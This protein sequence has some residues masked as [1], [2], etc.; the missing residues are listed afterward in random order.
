MYD[1]CYSRFSI[2]AINSNQE[3]ILLKNVY[4]SLNK[5]GKFFIETRCI[6]DDIFGLGEKIDK[7]TYI[8]NDHYR[9]FIDKN[10]LIS[11][12]KKIGFIIDY[13]EEN[14]GFAPYGDSDPMILRII[15]KR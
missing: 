6:K 8:Y 3:T 11:K 1:Y 12:M 13:A 2:H 9:R 15:G 4:N 5:N 7:N 14:R 10:E